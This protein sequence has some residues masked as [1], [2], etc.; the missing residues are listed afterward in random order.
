MVA[1]RPCNVANSTGSAMLRPLRMLAI[2]LRSAPVDR[3]TF[4]WYIFAVLR[5][6]LST[7]S[8]EVR[9]VSQQIWSEV[10]EVC[11]RLMDP[12]ALRVWL[13]PSRLLFSFFLMS[14][15][16]FGSLNCGLGWCILCIIMLASWVAPWIAASSESIYRDSMWLLPSRL[17]F[18]F[19]FFFFLLSVVSLTCG[20]GWCI[21]CII[22]YGSWVATAFSV[23]SAF[24]VLGSW[25][26]ALSES[27]YC[28]PMKSVD[29]PPDSGGTGTRTNQMPLPG[30]YSSL[31]WASDIA[32]WLSNESMSFLSFL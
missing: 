11:E 26:A 16:L 23:F 17:L 12:Q 18:F 15:H 19:F 24:S 9:C 31:P 14:L 25:V 1:S 32:S 3:A 28:D 7:R 10:S 30:G 6:K 29:A 27:I 20:L 5:H 2:Y 21:L 8:A 22:I 13:L 4:Q